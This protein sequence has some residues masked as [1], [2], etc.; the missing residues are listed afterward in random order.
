MSNP[1][2]IAIDSQ[3]N[4]WLPNITGGSITKLSS[5]G[6]P[7]S[8]STGYPDDVNQYPQAIAIDPNDNVWVANASSSYV[9]N[10]AKF[11]NSGAILSPPGGYVG[12]ASGMQ[13][14]LESMAIDGLGNVWTLNGN[15][16]THGIS[17]FSDLGQLLSPSNQALSDRVQTRHSNGIGNRH[18]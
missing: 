16:G 2:G 7:L 14:R 12:G 9:A 17:E 13:D 8:P 3:G 18:I 1:S 4:V 6:A 5:V 11:S 15:N 10:L